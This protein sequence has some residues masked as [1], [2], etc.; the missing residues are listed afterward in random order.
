MRRVWTCKQPPPSIPYKNIHLRKDLIVWDTSSN[1]IH[2]DELFS[3]SNLEAFQFNNSTPPIASRT[4]KSK[5]KQKLEAATEFRDEFQ[6]KKRRISNNDELRDAD[7][8]SASDIRSLYNIIP[9]VSRYPRYTGSGAHPLPYKIATFL[10]I[11][12]RPASGTRTG[13]RSKK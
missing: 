4:S 13:Q 6:S 9:Q 7:S 5:G 1:E 8:V 11:P 2:E 3:I 10:F 12:T